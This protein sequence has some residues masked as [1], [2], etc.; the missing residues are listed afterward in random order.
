M[1]NQPK[2]DMNKLKNT[3]IDPQQKETEEK[4]L[5]QII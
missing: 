1:L 3:H 5:I 4:R 2:I